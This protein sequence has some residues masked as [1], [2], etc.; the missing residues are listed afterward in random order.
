[1]FFGSGRGKGS[2]LFFFQSGGRV[3]GLFHVG[4]G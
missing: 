2:F 4:L 3:F 1:M